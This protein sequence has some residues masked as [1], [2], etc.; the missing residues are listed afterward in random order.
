[1]RSLSI[2]G[3]TIVIQRVPVSRIIDLRHAVLRAGL[4]RETAKFPGDEAETSRH[5]AAISEGDG[6]VVGCVTLHASAYEGEPAWQLRGMAVEEELRSKGVGE[7]LVSEM[8]REVVEDRAAPR[9]M[10]CNAR[11]PAVRFYERLGW[12]KVSEEFVIPTAG[13]HL[14]MVKRLEGNGAGVR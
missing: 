1:M 7:A 10:W 6:R 13:P 9:V 11:T 5:Y 2:G 4:P 8:E 14:R 3:E 12:E